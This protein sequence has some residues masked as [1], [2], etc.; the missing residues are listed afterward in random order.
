MFMSS[1]ADIRYRV[2]PTV[3]LG[4]S[5]KWMVRAMLNASNSYT[6]TFRLE[7]ATA[8]AK[9]R[10]YSE[11]DIHSHFRMAAFARAALAL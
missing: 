3:S 9:Y 10:F 8:Y 5:K 11:D 4:L 7:G 6:A 1:D 2:Q